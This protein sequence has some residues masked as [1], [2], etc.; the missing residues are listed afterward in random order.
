MQISSRRRDLYV[1]TAHVVCTLPAAS[2]AWDVVW[3]G[4][5]V[6][7]VWHQQP[8]VV[9]PLSPHVTCGTFTVSQKLITFT[10]V[11]CT[12]LQACNQAVAFTAC[13]CKYE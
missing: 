2:N 5:Y 11:I 7:S 6:V 4:Q 13:A 10:V 9:V 12:A 8:G 1:G 3:Q